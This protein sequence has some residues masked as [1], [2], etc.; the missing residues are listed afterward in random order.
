MK[1]VYIEKVK[2]NKLGAILYFIGFLFMSISGIALLFKTNATNRIQILAWI[3]LGIS[4][5]YLYTRFDI[6]VYSK[7]K[8]EKKRIKKYNKKEV[9]KLARYFLMILIISFIINFT[10]FFYLMGT[11]LPNL[12]IFFLYF[13]IALGW[14]MITVISGAFILLWKNGFK[15]KKIIKKLKRRK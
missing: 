13:P 15:F 4:G 9:G 5:Y 8:K 1:E 7:I 14:T 11:D 3:L 2:I 10:T 6:F 12:A